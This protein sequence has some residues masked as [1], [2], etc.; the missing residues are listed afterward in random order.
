MA[1]DGSIVFETKIDNAG[2]Q[3][4][5]NALEKS[6]E[7]IEKNI[8]KMEGEKSGL[9][10]QFRRAGEALGESELKLKNMRAEL[11]QAK[12]VLAG[13]PGFELPLEEY[14]RYSDL[15][16]SLPGKIAEQEREYQR[17]GAE[18]DK[19]SAKLADYDDRIAAATEELGRQQEEAGK[20]VG[21]VS[22]GSDAFDEIA[23]NAEVADQKI[24]DM[25][26]EL[27]ELKDKLQELKKRGLGLGHKEYDDTLAKI[28][29]LTTALK[30]YQN[31]KEGKDT[32]PRTKK[33]AATTKSA[34]KDTSRSDR[35]AEKLKSILSKVSQAAK[36]AGA[37]LAKVG[38]LAARAFTGAAKAAA[39]FLRQ[40]NVF[41]R[42]SERLSDTMKRLGGIIKSAFIF[43]VISQGLNALKGQV[44][45]Y[46]STNAQFT[47]ALN[48]LKGTL[49]GA[50][51]PILNAAVPALVTLINV[52]SQVIA[53]IGRFIGALFSIGGK[54]KSNVKAM[55]AEAAAI[56]GAGAA[57]EEAA[58]SLASFDEI[59]KL[60]GDTGGG[61]GGG[62]GGAG[63]VD[64]PEYDF[65]TEFTSWGEAFDAFLDTILNKG[66]PALKAAFTEFADWLN[67]FSKNLYEMF[68]FPGVRDKVILIGKELANAFNGLVD[69]IDWQ[70]L[71]QALGAGL[72]LALLLAVNAIY[73]FDWLNLGR[74]IADFINGAISEIEWSEMGRLL[75]AGFKIGL[76]T[77]AGFIAGLDMPLVANALSDMI[78]GFWNSA[79]ETVN[80]IPWG[81]IGE[82][83]GIFLN[84]FD[85]YGT[86]NS[87]LTTIIAA[88]GGLKTS[89]DSFLSTWD[90]ENTAQQIYTAINNAISGIN[91]EGLGETLGQLF[92]TVLGFISTVIS[93]TNWLEIGRGLG[94][95][96][97]SIFDNITWEDIKKTLLDAVQGI[98]DA[99]R[100]FI[101]T[102][103]P[104]LIAAIGLAIASIFVGTKVK[105]I[106]AFVG[107]FALL[108][109]KMREIGSVIA[110]AI[111]KINFAQVVGDL[112]AMLGDAI[113]DALDLL[114]G[115]V[116]TLDWYS[117]GLE[118]WNGLVDAVQRINWGKIISQIFELLGAAVGGAVALV[119]G[120]AKGIW[121]SIVSALFSVGDYFNDKINECGGNIIEGI[122]KGIGDAIAGIGAWINDNIFQ[123][124]IQGFCSVFGINSP[125]TVMAEQGGYIV[126]GLLQGVTQAWGD[127]VNFFDEKLQAVKE[128]IGKAW[129]NVKKT[130]REIWDNVSTSL[131]ETWDKVKGW[132][133]DKF[134]TAKETIGNA[135]EQVKKTTG[136]IWDNVSTTVS[137]TWDK[138][139]GWAGEKFNAAKEAIS[140][141]WSD[142]QSD[143]EKTWNIVSDGLHKVWEGLYSS[144]DEKFNRIK[145]G[146]AAVWKNAETNTKTVWASTLE[147]L[148]K[149]W[150]LVENNANT[151]FK[152][153]AKNVKDAWS[154]ISTNTTATWR[155][156]ESGLK[157]SFGAIKDAGIKAFNSMNSSVSN[158]YS[159]MG[160]NIRN[161]TN[162][163]IDS[164]N[165]M[166]NG[167]SVGVS[168]A[169]NA[170]NS[171]RASAGA[172][173]SYGIN[174]PHLATGAVIPPNREFMA[175]L[176]DQRSGNNIEA[177]EALIRK[178]VREESG[179]GNSELLRAILEA[180]RAGQVIMVDRQ[181]LGR[182]VTREQNR[183]TRA[184]GRSAVLN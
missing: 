20:L 88:L 182:V 23:E 96:I 28:H 150:E 33:A 98:I 128:T 66:I 107:V 9:E 91:W 10:E 122:F 129:E 17:L 30:E 48:N 125:S 157:S 170:L 120:L 139:K 166:T 5:L 16:S 113:E 172:A 76:E 78:K 140:T 136:D 93:G 32:A 53:A 59:N 8:S 95:A 58:K 105:L 87:V 38:N 180:I 148:K 106:A 4:D 70:L 37:A 138:I 36:T 22:K 124:F 75:W 97:Q 69:M 3:K 77:L 178:I 46:L 41:S 7:R 84:E 179:D 43:N 123:P 72:N 164:I 2:A 133:K 134:D 183:S 21:E 146:I 110:E 145:D 12:A 14:I 115:F 94:T 131:G 143:T 52:I 25:A 126:S 152:K 132:A 19:L 127:I 13:T 99:V 51:Q 61:G 50:F 24:V 176:G 55:N 45:S 6:I 31:Q 18:T 117:L 54:S 40:M 11:E 104:E 64:I 47:A 155:P 156:L 184:S 71:G 137:G 42:V 130:T 111:N 57:A 154:A 108:K 163:I 121:D 74:S 80:N 181:V 160:N 1:A 161:T 149:T 85:W 68:T 81:R 119:E 49:A 34:G 79:L 44:A 135:W 142:S 165:R 159:T 62:G 15:V 171:V 147:G 158:A 151:E 162:A 67:N 100:G 35:A 92:A 167:V 177:P 39:G 65:D 26:K 101:E 109:D 89:I 29:E 144:S 175:V 174:I 82:Q 116:E 141:A 102:S 90:W 27:E 118:L 112:G 173:R 86:I 63:A 103:P 168:N 73:G 153:T 114:I 56:G 60:A 83:I 169:L